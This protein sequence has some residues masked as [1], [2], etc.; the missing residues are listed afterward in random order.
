MKVRID[1]DGCTEC[2][3]CSDTCPKVFV[4]ENGEKARIS[5]EFQQDGPATG[6]VSDE[7]L[8]KCTKQAA[9][10]CPVDVIST[11]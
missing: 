10:D 6:A 8:I 1:R 5:E 2:G 11:D 9:D 4:V 7:E 3:A